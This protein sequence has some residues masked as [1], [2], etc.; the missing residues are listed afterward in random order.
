[1][2]KHTIRIKCYEFPEEEITVEITGRVS[3]DE[4][5]AEIVEFLEH[6][7]D[8]QN[9]RAAAKRTIGCVGSNAWNYGAGSWHHQDGQ[10][11]MGNPNDNNINSCSTLYWKVLDEVQNNY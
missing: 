2:T 4:L 7:G 6:T 1:M 9:L 3:G 5:C 10:I 11:I 8:R